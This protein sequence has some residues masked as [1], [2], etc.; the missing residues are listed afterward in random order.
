LVDKKN[1]G[2]E[3]DKPRK[4][5]E[6]GLEGDPLTKT[7]SESRGKVRGTRHREKTEIFKTST[8]R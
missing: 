4:K 6:E 7:N 1:R 3:E 8:T 2:E 5:R